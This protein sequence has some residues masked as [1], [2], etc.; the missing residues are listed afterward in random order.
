[1]TAAQ[2]AALP[3]AGGEMTG[4][5]L[6]TA[7]AFVGTFYYVDSGGTAITPVLDKELVT[8]L[9]ADTK[10]AKLDPTVQYRIVIDD[11]NGQVESSGASILDEG[12]AGTIH[13]DNVF[14][15]TRTTPLEGDGWI[16]DD[17][18]RRWIMQN[19]DGVVRKS[20]LIVTKFI[21]VV[22]TVTGLN[23][24][25]LTTPPPETLYAGTNIYAPEFPTNLDRYV[26]IVLQTHHAWVEDTD[27]DLHIHWE[28]NGAGGVGD[29]PRWGC[30]HLSKKIGGTNVTTTTSYSTGNHLSEDIVDRK[31]Y[32]TDICT[33]PAADLGMSSILKATVWRDGSDVLDTYSGGCWGLDIDMHIQ[34]DAFGSEEEYVK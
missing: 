30:E 5:I 4:D 25:G 14:T 11:G 28:A 2:A 21:D 31:H 7:I 27:A 9:Y 3:T 15:V 23:P 1:M 34:V 29:T 13:R 18:R 32:V 19:Y 22:G 26:Q 20:E 8:K 10:I 33:I 12:E 16:Y 17:G 6:G 24:P